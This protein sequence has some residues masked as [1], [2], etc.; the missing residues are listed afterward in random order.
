MRM[1]DERV[2]VN[3][4]SFQARSTPNMDQIEH[5]VHYLKMLG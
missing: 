1:G 4:S 3:K 2:A 5:T